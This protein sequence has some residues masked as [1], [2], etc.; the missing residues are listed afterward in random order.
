MQRSVMH[1]NNNK[2]EMSILA[3][4]DGFVFSVLPCRLELVRAAA[5]KQGEL[6]GKSFVFDEP[7]HRDVRILYNSPDGP[8]RPP[9]INIGI[10]LSEVDGVDGR[11][12]LFVSSVADGYSSMIAGVSREISGTHLTFEVSRPDVRYPGC[13]SYAI[14]DGKSVRTVHA[15][16]DNNWVFFEKGELLPFEQIDHYCARRKKD[17]LSVDIIS[18]YINRLGYGSLDMGFWIDST[19]PAHFL[20]TTGFRM[21]NPSKRAVG[22]FRLG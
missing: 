12:T 19:A 17:R 11:K 1:S 2:A 14:R 5:K 6:W 10:L 15:M 21:W 3:L 13:A 9:A 20:A 4:F 8:D 22:D 18:S 16:L 7:K